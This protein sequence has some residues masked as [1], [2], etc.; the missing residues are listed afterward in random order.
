M[1]PKGEALADWYPGE[2][3]RLHADGGAG[4]VKEYS[5][6]LEPTVSGSYHCDP[7]TAEAVA[8][9]GSFAPFGLRSESAHLTRLRMRY[10]TEE[11]TADLQL[12]VSGITGVDDQ[13][14][15]ISQLDELENLFPYCDT[16]WATNPTTC[17]DAPLL[18]GSCDMPAPQLSS[19]VLLGSLALLRR[20][21]A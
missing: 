18:G 6:D 8:P 5:W 13:I 15:V 17:P 4:W 19:M 12:Y 9:G 7:C 10:T 14:K 21:R 16:G 3:D 20:R 11:A 2:L 1:L